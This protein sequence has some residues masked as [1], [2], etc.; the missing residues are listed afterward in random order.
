M[1]E[2]PAKQAESHNRRIAIIN[3][4]GIIRVD[5]CRLGASDV[6]RSSPV[7][8]GALGWTVTCIQARAETLSQRPN[9]PRESAAVFLLPAPNRRHPT[10]RQSRYSRLSAMP[11]VLSHRQAPARMPRE[12]L[13]TVSSTP[14][15]A[16]VQHATSSRPT[17]ISRGYQAGYMP[18]LAEYPHMIR[19]MGEDTSKWCPSPLASEA[20][21]EAVALHQALRDAEDSEEV[22]RP[23][24]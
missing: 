4:K 2:N 16:R 17:Q 6:E 9:H 24:L 3:A 12:V 21:A 8:L 5:R 18:D 10:P 15:P 13:P 20:Y 22:V 14:L 7:A 23:L 11:V 19:G 1:R